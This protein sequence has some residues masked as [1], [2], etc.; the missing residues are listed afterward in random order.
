MTKVYS[1]LRRALA[2]AMFATITLAVQAT[3]YKNIHVR[4]LVNE[5]GR[6]KVYLKTEDP[7]NDQ[8]RKRE[9]VS[10]KCTLG[11]NGNDTS[12]DADDPLRGLYGVWL[13][14]EPGSGYELAGF[15]LSQKADNEY[16]K[17][18]LL[19]AATTDN[20]G[21]TD[22]YPDGFMFNANCDRPEDANTNDYSDSDAAREGAR[23]KNNWNETPDHTIYAV[24]LPTGTVLPDGDTDGIQ[25]VTSTQSHQRY[26]INGMKVDSNHKGIVIINGKKYLL[27]Q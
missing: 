15:S 1:N 14:A 7:S 13:Y 3:P 5:T 24:L 20:S 4:L 6:G 22:P 27:K 16:T 18:D 17:A 19:V 9:D 10:L 25:A 11:E 26:S 21:W 12:R 2:I 23:A 8:T